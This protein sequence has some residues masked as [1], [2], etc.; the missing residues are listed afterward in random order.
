MPAERVAL[1]TH[2][3]AASPDQRALWARFAA[4]VAAAGPS[5]TV[6]TKSRVAFRAHRIFAGG[7]FS[8][9]RRLEIFI[10]LP[11]P[12]P[13]YERDSRFRAVWEASP[14]LWT[15]RLTIEE[16]NDL[17]ERLAGWLK[18]SWATYSRPPRER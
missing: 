5:E 3:G 14:R 17:D 4:L 13:E 8:G 7:F 1:D 18:D 9:R 10:D 12:V 11:A 16:P 2:L 6:V 15:H